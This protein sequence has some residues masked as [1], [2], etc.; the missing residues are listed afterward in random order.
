MPLIIGQTSIAAN[1]TNGNVLSGSAYEFMPYNALLEIGL[2]SNAAGDHQCTVYSGSDALLEESGVS[3]QA[4]VP[5]YPDDF[6]IRDVALGGERLTIR[7]RNTTGVAATIF[8]SVKITP[9]G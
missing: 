4:R 7:V 1:A 9:L 6:S 3:R 8:W 5:V 2:C